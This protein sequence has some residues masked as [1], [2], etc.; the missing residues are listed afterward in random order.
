MSTLGPGLANLVVL[1]KL[2]Q[3]KKKGN[4]VVA[5]MSSELK[6]KKKNVLKSYIHSL[7]T[8]LISLQILIKAN[9]FEKI[10]KH[11]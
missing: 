1:L 2:V 9:K 8:K 6:K 3:V 10:L 5:C 7:E 11:K 4:Q